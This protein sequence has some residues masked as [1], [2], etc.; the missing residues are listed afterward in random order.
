M[1]QAE[2]TGS[3]YAPAVVL[4]FGYHDSHAITG[5]PL[6]EWVK[7]FP[8]RQFNDADKSW[9]ITA[10]G[11][12]PD[13]TFTEAGITVI[14]PDGRPAALNGLAKAAARARPGDPSLVEVHPRLD[15]PDLVRSHMGATAMWRKA[16]SCW[17][18]PSHALVKAGSL[19]GWCEVPETIVQWCEKNP[20]VATEALPPLP[21]DGNIDGLRGVGLDE[22]AAVSPVIAD[23][24]RATGI[25][26][27]HD[28][29]HTLPRRYIDLPSPGQVR[30]FVPGT[31]ATVFGT[32]TKLEVPKERG[33]MSKATIRDDAGTYLHVRWFHARGLGRR[34]PVGTRVI[35][36]GKLETFPYS[37][38][39]NGFGMTNPLAEP[40]VES[41]AKMIGVYPASG[42]NELATWQVF[43]AAREAARRLGSM[44]DP[45]PPE[46][47][48]EHGLPDRASAY[49]M[50]HDPASAD[51]AQSGRDRLA[52]DE[53][54]RLQLVISAA[55]AANSG[56]EATAHVLTGDLM[57]DFLAS[58]PYTPTGAQQRAVTAILNDMAVPAPMH[59]LLQGDVGS[60]KT[61]VALIAML[62]AVENGTQAAMIAPNEILALQHF[63]DVE[64]SL[65]GLTKADGEPVQV[66]LLTGKVTGKKR[67]ETLAGMADGSIDIVIGTHALLDEKVVFHDLTV[68]VIDEQHRF[69]VEQRAA[70]R[71]KGVRVPDVLYASATPVPR[72]AVLT[73]FGD[74]DLSVLDE[75]PPGRTPISTHHISGDQ[76]D[77]MDPASMAWAA[78]RTAVDAGHQAFVV[79]P[80]VTSSATREAAAAHATAEQL[81][82]GALA[83]MRIG[84]ITGKD[85]PAD[86]HATMADF[87][88]KK[89]D[90]LVATT[91]IEVGVNIP[92]ATVMVVLGAEK[93]GLAQLH[94]LRGRVGRGH[95]AGRCILVGDPK[96][97]VAKQ[98]MEAIV[99][100]TD[101]FALAELDL[102][103]RGAGQVL[104]TAQ[105]G[106]GRDL[107]VASVTNDRKLLAWANED[108]AAL[109]RDDP[110]LVRRPGLR[111]EVA[112]AVG[113]EA[114][115][116][117]MSA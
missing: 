20:V 109:T 73:T 90:V 81:G 112:A 50:V 89:L 37:D 16:D 5:E 51:E 3:W 95:A 74:L 57:R 29:L 38:G 64:D 96:T 4:S 86:R 75:M 1:K 111:S 44:I 84:V 25:S 65:F 26:N 46:L 48:G 91:V 53:L 18:L 42:V 116:W 92:N 85:T 36:H 68:A 98:R 114:A 27:V 11:K 107:R 76:A 49:R 10:T 69:G 99:S 30:Q 43:A 23:A 61:L 60:G 93:F 15:G 21:F 105:S 94:Q 110:R 12:N 103:I 62:G 52:Y 104:G 102:E 66:R 97:A 82:I 83:G 59:R 45:V 113:E 100:T 9:T 71:A 58:L 13:R 2:I 47:L 24:M 108:A 70:L 33:A 39:G 41:S 63:E 56:Q 34:I 79:V 115:A 19:V 40:I 31:T 22:L 32:V 54:L 72:T 87:A 55:K 14:G 88:A 101:G 77:L 7:R 17:L 28:L 106:T 117:L 6:R 35:M 80:L 8:G 78:V 67:K